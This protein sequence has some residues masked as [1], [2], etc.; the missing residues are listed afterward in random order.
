MGKCYS[1]I[2]NLYKRI[3]QSTATREKT[4]RNTFVEKFRVNTYG[5]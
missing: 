3:A 2:V 1:L 5:Y 4:P